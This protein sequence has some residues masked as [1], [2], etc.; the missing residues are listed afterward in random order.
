MIN[1]FLFNR[2]RA[3]ALLTLLASLSTATYADDFKFTARLS[4]AQEAV[5]D[6]NEDFVPGGIDT[7]ARGRIR[8]D[9]NKSLS[10]LRVKLRFRNLLG[11]FAA[12]HFHCNRAGQNGPV[13]FGLVNPGPLQPDGDRVQGTLTNLNFTG[14][15]CVP[16]I[17]RPVNNLAALEAAMRD[18]LIYINVHSSAHPAGEIRGQMRDQKH[19]SN[20]KHRDR[21]KDD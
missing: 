13:V 7:A 16:L 3:L 9:F 20:R 12:A 10:E 11:T 17:G 19:H 21:D 4:G 5:F 1:A 15:D 18:G 14:A 8:A 2:L 6:A